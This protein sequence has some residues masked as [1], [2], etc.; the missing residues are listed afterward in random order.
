LANGMTQVKYQYQLNNP[1]SFHLPPTRAEG[2]YMP[3]VYAETPNATMD[4]Q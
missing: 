4:V 3:G 2:V 1:G